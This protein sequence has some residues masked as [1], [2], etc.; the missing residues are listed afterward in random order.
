[1]SPLLLLSVLG[2]AQSAF[3]V[4]Q[5]GQGDR[6]GEGCR[7]AMSKDARMPSSAL[8]PFLLGGLGSLINP[9][10]QRRVPF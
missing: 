3:Q 1:M 7:V 6:H 9:F 10:K 5:L 4:T 2:L 8:I